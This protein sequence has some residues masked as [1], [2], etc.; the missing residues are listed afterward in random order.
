MIRECIGVFRCTE[1]AGVVLWVTMHMCIVARDLGV[2]FPR[3]IVAF[4]AL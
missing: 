1:T 3:K 4:Y 2:C